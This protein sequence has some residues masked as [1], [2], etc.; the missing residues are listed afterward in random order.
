MRIHFAALAL[1]DAGRLDRAV[2]HLRRAAELSP[3]K[4][5]VRVALATALGRMG[6]DDE[7][8]GL[9]KAAV[10]VAP[11]DLQAQRGL[12]ETL[13]KQGRPQALCQALAQ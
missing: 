1:S 2:R 12:G 10:E 5:E 11:R 13:L 9:L 4:T 3:A 7:A 6:Q 8:V